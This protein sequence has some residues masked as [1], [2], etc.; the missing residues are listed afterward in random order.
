MTTSMR[1]NRATPVRSFVL[2]TALAAAAITQPAAAQPAR[3]ELAV[4]EPW[5]RAAV[6]GGN[7]GAFMTLRNGGDQADRLVSA[8]SPAART[9]E[10]HTTVRDGDVMRMRPVDAIEVPGHGTVALQPGGL[11]VM[12]IGLDR[13]LAQGEHVPLTLRFERAGDLAVELAVRA[14]GA[15]GMGSMQGPS[16]TGARPAPQR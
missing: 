13:P 11:H 4:E 1:T 6:R 12:L 9:V 15:G 10:L 14:A 3:R 2:A 7:G 16:G 8:T 5:A